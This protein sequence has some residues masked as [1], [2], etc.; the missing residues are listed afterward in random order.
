MTT[1][2]ITRT[3]QYSIIISDTREN[4][5]EESTYLDGVFKLRYIPNMGFI[6]GAG[7]AV[8]LEEVKERI[9]KKRRIEHI[10]EVLEIFKSTADEGKRD[11]LGTE[12]RIDNSYIAITWLGEDN[13]KIEYQSGLLSES[14]YEKNGDN[15]MLVDKGGIRII[16]PVDLVEKDG[17]IHEIVEQ[18][19]G[20]I[21]TDLSINK[22]LFETLKLFVQIAKNSDLVSLDCQI[23][24]Q[25]HSKLTNEIHTEGL[26]GKGEQ[27]LKLAQQNKIL[28]KFK[29][30]GTLSEFV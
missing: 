5:E 17:L 16:Y 26:Y 18:T 27:L 7:W 10:D 12:E 25:Y 13:N 23:G 24:I 28:R 19:N 6:T 11:V 29:A 20:K 14:Y 30:A 2:I 9:I 4:N 8:F 1:I 22:A 15:S 21:T 3:D